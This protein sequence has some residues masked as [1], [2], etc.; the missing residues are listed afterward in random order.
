MAHINH[1]LREVDKAERRSKIGR[2][3]EYRIAQAESKGFKEAMARLHRA[4]RIAEA[5][6]QQ[7]TGYQPPQGAPPMT[8]KE[9]EALQGQQHMKFANLPADEQEQFTAQRDAMWSQIPEHL[10]DKA[11]KMAGH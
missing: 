9:I 1:F 11:R 8:E 6:E 4:E 2:I 5:K 7:E 3:Y 10:R